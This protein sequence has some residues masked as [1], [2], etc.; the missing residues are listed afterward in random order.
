LSTI[1]RLTAPQHERVFLSDSNG[2][3]TIGQQPK[4]IWTPQQ[5]DCITQFTAWL[6]TQQKT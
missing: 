6:Q 4:Q 5:L 2:T 1:K 3:S